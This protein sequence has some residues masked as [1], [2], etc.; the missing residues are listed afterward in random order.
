MKR[1]IGIL[2]TQTIKDSFVVALG[3]GVSATIGF[4]FTILLARSL[5]PVNFG[6]Y[7]ALT[8]LA[9]IVYSLGDMGISSSLINFLPKKVSE[10]YQYLSTS[11]WME[12][13]IGVFILLLFGI[14]SIFHQT[15][16]PGS[17]STDL[18]LAGV[19]SFNYLLIIYTQGVFTAGRKFWSYTASQILD[20]G[21]KI[22]IVFFIFKT[23]NLSIGTALIANII[24]TFI[25]L[26]ITFGK[27]LYGIEF[28]FF[29]K[30]FWNIFHFAKWIAVSR[31]FTVMISRIDIVLLNLLV[32]SY[33]AGIFS[34]ASR[35]TLLFAMLAA[36]LGS[37]I[38]PRFSSFDSN[39]KIL[40]YGKKLL[41]LVTGVAVSMILIS[42]LAAPIITLVYGQK[43][44]ESISVFRYLIFAMIPFLF[45][46]IFNSILVYGFNKLSYYT[47][48]MATQTIIIVTLDLL[49]IPR[50]G[51]HAPAISLLFSNLF[52]FAAS[53]LKIRSLLHEK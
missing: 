4:V 1:I 3:L 23:G 38:N 32:G 27:E 39:S 34:A 2:R 40:A 11:F 21:V 8:A 14:F 35:V 25:A 43:Y 48:M 31:L 13:V 22:V 46:I 10:R 12:F 9:A 50:I 15:L 41:L 6:V 33:S 16:V 44:L 28:D 42:F 26:L 30:P 37:V 29:K 5:G 52:V 36:G 53:T 17:L 49:L 20:S 45:T 19:I 47:K 7:S 18:L 24:S 51:Y